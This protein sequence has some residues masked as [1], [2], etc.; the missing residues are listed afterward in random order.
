MNREIKFRA[1]QD[2]QMLISPISSNY[3]LHR[4][5]GMLYEDAPIMQFT[6]KKDKNGVD[7]YEGDIIKWSC[8]YDDYTEGKEVIADVKFLEQ[9]TLGWHFGKL[10]KLTGDKLWCDLVPETMEVIGNIYQNADILMIRKVNIN[11]L[12]Y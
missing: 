1:W 3:G 4:F 5:F 6:G 11:G 8:E 10:R 9:D 12:F 2:N 7:I